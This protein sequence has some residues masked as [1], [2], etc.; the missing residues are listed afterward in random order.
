M[1]DPEIVKQNATLVFGTEVTVCT[2]TNPHSFWEAY[3]MKKTASDIYCAATWRLYVTP[4]GGVRTLVAEAPVADDSQPVRLNWSSLDMPKGNRYELVAYSTNPKSSHHD[5]TAV[6]SGFD[7]SAPNAQATVNGTA[8]LPANQVEQIL[9]TLNAE[10]QA[11]DI[12]VDTSNLDGPAIFIVYVTPSVGVRVPIFKQRFTHAVGKVYIGRIE[13]CSSAKYELVGISLSGK[14]TAAGIKGD[15]VGSTPIGSGGGGGPLPMSPDVTGFT[16]NN[17]LSKISAL[18]GGGTQFVG[19]DNSG[20]VIAITPGSTRQISADIRDFGAAAS[21]TDIGPAINAAFA[22][23]YQSV[24][25]PKRFLVDGGF[26]WGCTT[27]VTKATPNDLSYEIIGDPSGGTYIQLVEGQVTPF[28]L[29]C[30]DGTIRYA[31]LS[32]IGSAGNADISPNCITIA[33]ARLGIIERCDF[34]GLA[35]T[36]SAFG[37]VHTSADMAVM[38]DCNFYGCDYRGTAKQGGVVSSTG[39]EDGLNY[40]NIRF[41]GS[42]VLNGVTYS[43]SSVTQTWLWFGGQGEGGVNQPG[44]YVEYNLKNIWMSEPELSCMEFLPEGPTAGPPP[45]GQFIILHVRII[46]CGFNVPSAGEFAIEASFAYNVHIEDCD[47][48]GSAGGTVLKISN[49]DNLIWKYNTLGNGSKNVVFGT[50]GTG[51]GYV[52][53]EQPTQNLILDDSAFSPLHGLY[54]HNGF[55]TVIYPGPKGIPGL[56]AMYD[57]KLG[58]TVAGGKV[59]QWNEQFSGDPQENAVQA[60]AANQPAYIASD[61]AYAGEPML[62][63]AGAQFLQTGAW[64]VPPPNTAT[65]IMVGNFDNTATAEIAIADNAL[66]VYELYQNGPNDLHFQGQGGFDL[67]AAGT[68]PDLDDPH[69][70]CISISPTV[71]IPKIRQDETSLFAASGAAGTGSPNATGL[72]LG[73]QPAGVNGLIGKMGLVLL[74][75]HI[76]TPPELAT[77][78]RYATSRYEI[79][80]Q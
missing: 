79:L 75:D 52:E 62:S 67:G 73:A 30:N 20:N 51:T 32:F 15:F 72:T 66:N 70:W 31:D 35:C 43:K 44:N 17:A 37:V 50:L 25:I 4:T 14:A 56:L 68:T 7:Y 1:A 10:Y 61:P 49:W 55:E 76:L 42:G 11:V 22:A 28:T 46:G 23:G 80:V 27:P 19:V 3:V 40:E 63:M 45:H 21:P 2:I 13:D 33:A 16:N 78:V 74:Y 39:M 12:S 26:A 36:A 18:A 29:G 53:F 6:L 65:L 57:P 34:W 64:L 38:R 41:F 60:T 54:I 77:V 8:V 24:Y 69:V 9:C 48:F 59:S 71:N 58:V 47:F 5:V